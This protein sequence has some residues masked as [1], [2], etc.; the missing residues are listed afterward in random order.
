VSGSW[1]WSLANCYLSLVAGCCQRKG[2]S[3]WRRQFREFRRFKRY[4]LCS[5]RFAFKSTI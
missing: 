5:M 1:L 3:A 2:H 4:A